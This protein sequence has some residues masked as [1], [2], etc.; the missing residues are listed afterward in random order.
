MVEQKQTSTNVVAALGDGLLKA[1]FFQFWKLLLPVVLAALTALFGFL[2]AT[3]IPLMWIVFAT[4]G[5]FCFG[6]ISVVGISIYRTQKSDK[7]KLCLGDSTCELTLVENDRV[8]LFATEVQ[9]RADFPLYVECTL[10]SAQVDGVIS[11]KAHQHLSKFCLLPG[12]KA[13]YRSAA[14]RMT[15]EFETALMT[16][17]PA[18]SVVKNGK[19][20]IHFRYGARPNALNHLMERDY[21]VM[22]EFIDGRAVGTLTHDEKNVQ[23]VS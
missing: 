12:V 23:A 9:N 8:L 18:N 7:F 10:A 11:L 1:L 17:R 6:A 22:V 2:S 16:K 21:R 3:P 15:H 19:Y 20:S 14:V 13:P 4:T 5:V